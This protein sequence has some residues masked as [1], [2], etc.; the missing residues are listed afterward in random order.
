MSS[1]II[2]TVMAVV[3]ALFATTPVLAQEKGEMAV[4]GGVSVATGD[5]Y[6]NVG[7]GAKFQWNPINNLRLEPSFN[8][9]FKKDYL[10][11]WDLSA[12]LHYLIPVGEVVTLYPLA[13]VGIQNVGL[14]ADVDLGYWGK[15]SFNESDTH[16][17]F[18]LGA[19][20]DIK[21][22]DNW[23]LNFEFKYKIADLDRAVFSLGVAYKF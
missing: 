16:F 5:S 2:K 17:A 6:T 20:A 15:Y 11:T 21:L 14:D 22:S 13:G 10:S 8:Y 4:G 1:K 3:I 9:F 23:N 18:N 19:G 12:N 7:L